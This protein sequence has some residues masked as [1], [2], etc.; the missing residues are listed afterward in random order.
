MRSSSLLGLLALSLLVSACDGS[1]YL[2]PQPANQIGEKLDDMSSLNDDTGTQI[3]KIVVYDDTVGRIHQFNLDTMNVERSLAVMNPSLPH[4]VLYNLGGNYVIDFTTKHLSVFDRNGKAVHNPIRFIGTPVSA[5]YRPAMGLIVIYDSLM[6]VGMM[7]IGPNGEVTKSWKGGPDLGSNRT[8]A[9]GD[10]DDGGR[11]VL[12]LSDDTLVKV[13]IDATMTSGTWTVTG[14]PIATGLTDVEWVAPVRGQPDQVMVAT[15]DKLEI[16]DTNAGAVLG[17]AVT[18]NGSIVKRTKGIDAHI[19]TTDY[20]DGGV[21]IYYADGGAILNKQLYRATGVITH[22]RLDK[23]NNNLTLVTAAYYDW[24]WSA[25]RGYSV[26]DKKNR[27]IRQWR[28]SDL[29]AQVEEKVVDD[30]KLALASRSLF[31]LK[32]NKLGWALNYDL[33]SG[34]P[35]A[36]RQSFNVPYIP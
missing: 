23:T 4:T 33:F 15:K 22:S 6:S 36:E 17:A 18:L 14:A 16:V 30:A 7:R 19:I 3:N 1:F 9:A 20:T 28:F 24:S 13:D 25:A 27:M 26:S 31:A 32:E 12:A 8:I 10:I 35:P 21:W 2:Q 5:A 11:L 29:D 34:G